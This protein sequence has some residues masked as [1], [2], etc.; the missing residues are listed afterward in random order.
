ML[1][2]PGIYILGILL[3]T[4]KYGCDPKYVQVWSSNGSFN[5]HLISG[6][7]NFWTT[8]DVIFGYHLYF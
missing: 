3:G 4:L 1:G 7:F 5:R 8:I 2:M 6:P